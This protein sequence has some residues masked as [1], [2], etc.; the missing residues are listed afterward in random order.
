[1]TGP[2]DNGRRP[3]PTVI[4]SKRDALR[5]ILDGAFPIDQRGSFGDLLRQIDDQPGAT[6]K[7]FSN[8]AAD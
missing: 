2:S 5:G 3:G 4:A 8:D 7:L 1:M 6:G